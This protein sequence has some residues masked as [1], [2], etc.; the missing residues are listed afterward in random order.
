[1]LG[2]EPGDTLGYRIEDGRVSLVRVQQSAEAWLA[3]N[4]EALLEMA[5]WDRDNEIFAP[6]QHLF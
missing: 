5:A 2:I 1:V 4:K 6:D 3:A